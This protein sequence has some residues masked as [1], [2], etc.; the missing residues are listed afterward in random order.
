MN[1]G[2]L[3]DS[4]RAEVCS[5]DFEL[6]MLLPLAV[7]ANRNFRIRE[8]KGVASVRARIQC[9]ERRS[10]IDFEVGPELING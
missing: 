2:K 10:R 4:V 3:T 7:F 8:C 5:R 6:V 9:Q 1:D